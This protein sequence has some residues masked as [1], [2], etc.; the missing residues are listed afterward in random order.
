MAEGKAAPAALEGVAFNLS[1]IVLF[2]KAT[3]R[4]IR[5]S[6]SIRLFL[7]NITGGN[8]RMVIELMSS[9]CG[10][11]NVEAERIVTIERE[12]GAYQVPLHEFT[13]HALLGEYAYYN[14]LSS[15][16]ACNLFDI[17]TLDQREHHLC[18]LVISFI[19]SPMGIKD[20]DG[21][22]EGE[23][24]VKEMMR[25]GFGEDQ[26]RFSLKRLAAKR[27]I[28]TPHGHYRELKVEDTE[29]PERFHFRAT[30]VGLYH[31]RFWVAD[32]S[33]LDA[34]AIDTPIFNTSIRQQIFRTAQSHDIAIRMERAKAF[35][36]Y[37]ANTWNEAGFAVNYYDLPSVFDNQ[38]MSF[39][40]VENFL[41]RRNRNY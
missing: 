37:L 26:I 14:S 13:K 12:T 6:D 9:F 40:S 17:S 35:R 16:V 7:G 21:F 28:E 27:L 30:S 24:I 4:S 5:A 8:T 3:L 10:S 18:S 25:L 15:L 2:L 22:V 31:I 1:N 29:L 39:A 38:G 36:S 32:F 34:T 23:S 33:F 11:P 41:L 19:S 20:N